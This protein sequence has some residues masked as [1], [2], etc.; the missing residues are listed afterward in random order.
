[1]MPSGCCRGYANRTNPTSVCPAG[2]RVDPRSVPSSP[3]TSGR[4]FGHRR[5][6]DWAA[7]GLG[8]NS[9]ARSRRGQLAELQREMIVANTRDGLAAAR[10][11]GR[12]GGRRLKL[13][14]EQI[15][16]AQQLYDAGERTVQQ[17]ADIFKV[18]RTTVYGHLEHPAKASDPQSS[19]R[20]RAPEAPS[21]AARQRSTGEMAAGD[22]ILTGTPSSRPSDP[23][24]T[25]LDAAPPRPLALARRLHPRAGPHPRA[26]DARLTARHAHRRQHDRSRPPGARTAALEHPQTPKPPPTT[27][28]ASTSNRYPEDSRAAN[29]PLRPLAPDFSKPTRPDRWIRA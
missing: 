11:R 6:D 19:A 8:R 22:T 21:A 27:P 3:L 17:I 10:A 23:S 16:L 26:P 9:A 24:R 15:A 20:Q 1:M 13:N 2:E 5:R 28:P 14:P 18:P 4:R 29:P 12:K 7:P 25:R